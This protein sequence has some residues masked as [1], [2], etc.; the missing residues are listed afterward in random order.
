MALS[1]G[2]NR[3][4]LREWLVESLA[5]GATSM[6]R[7]ELE[8][9]AAKIMAAATDVTTPA[10]FA[11]LSQE[12]LEDIVL[13]SGLAAAGLSALA[14]FHCAVRRLQDAAEDA[15]EE[16]T[17]WEDALVRRGS[18]ALFERLPVD[19][20]HA[21]IVRL[22]TLALLDARSVSTSW[23]DWVEA[24][25]ELGSVD[26]AGAVWCCQNGTHRSGLS[27]ASFVYSFDFVDAAELPSTDEMHRDEPPRNHHVG[28]RARAATPLPRA[29]R[30]GM[31]GPA[32]ALPLEAKLVRHA[33]RWHVV[34]FW[35][36]AIHDSFGYCYQTWLV[37]ADDGRCC[38][39][40]RNC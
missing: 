35:E 18:F 25:G 16:R 9:I 13:S 29:M 17:G 28:Q 19:L 37:R 14:S 11:S 10:D 24:S 1:V 4:N 12:R 40:S 39:F 30:R 38:L 31:H 3:A 27:G 32:R 6:R 22:D 15:A 34:E 26:R 8:K 23:R 36:D 5:A 2:D 33:C 7:A 20:I 21:V